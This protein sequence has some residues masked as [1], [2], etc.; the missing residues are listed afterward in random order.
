MRGCMGHPPDCAG[1]IQ[2]AGHLQHV[3]REERERWK[4]DKEKYENEELFHEI[5]LH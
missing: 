4:I 5:L 2:V 1:A 3:V